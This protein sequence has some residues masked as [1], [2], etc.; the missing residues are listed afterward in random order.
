MKSSWKM[1]ISKVGPEDLENL[2]KFYL[3]TENFT[4]SRVH[5]L[6]THQNSVTKRIPR[7]V[8]VARRDRETVESGQVSSSDCD[9][10]DGRKSRLET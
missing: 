10:C 8:A 7:S 9:V 4:A 6:P 5:H 3:F 1:K 2:M